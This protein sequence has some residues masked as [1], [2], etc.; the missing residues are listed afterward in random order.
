LDNS[1]GK[2]STTMS[3]EETTN[4]NVEYYYPSLGFKTI[5]V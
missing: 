5:T 3:Y 1:S 4:N 2:A